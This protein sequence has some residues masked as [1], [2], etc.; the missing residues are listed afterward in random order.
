[1]SRVKRAQ[2]AGSRSPFLGPDAEGMERYRDS[3]RSSRL[4][5]E[6]G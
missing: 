5:G 1:M 6:D 3:E 4:V 2:L